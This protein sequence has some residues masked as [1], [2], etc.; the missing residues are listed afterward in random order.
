MK[1]MGVKYKIA[2]FNK[3]CIEVLPYCHNDFD[4]LQ[5]E[6]T[7]PNDINH[8]TRSEMEKMAM[9]SHGI[10]LPGPIPDF[11][12]V[13][14]Y[15]KS[16]K[17]RVVSIAAS[18]YEWFDVTAASNFGI[19]VTNAPVKEG[20]TAVADL[21]IGFMVCMSRMF[22]IHLSNLNKC[23]YSRRLIGNSLEGKTIGIIGLGNIG[24][25]VVRR[26]IGFG[27]TIIA[28]EPFP[29]VDFC[30]SNGVTVVDLETLLSESDIV[31]LHIR[32]NEN[33]NRMIGDRELRLMKKNVILINT[34]RKELCDEKAV[35]DFLQKNEEFQYAMDDIPSLLK[36]HHHLT[37]LQNF[38]CTPHIGNRTISGMCA[39]FKCAVISA[40]RV[41]KGEKPQYVL[42]P[43]LLE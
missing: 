11:P 38:L 13:E 16:K 14:T 5:V 39:V 4:N 12:N 28:C 43:D 15:R 40:I 42:N 22:K 3:S 10:I 41:C 37:E 7:V 33:T 8:I 27:L 19:I 32:L 26:A 31:S 35:F 17:L 1:E 23:E 29:D 24:K 25:E 36:D 34:A 18:G 9:E 21:T 6:I 2:V 20:A 30:N